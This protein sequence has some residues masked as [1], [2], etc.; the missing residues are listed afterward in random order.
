MLTSSVRALL[1]WAA[2]LVVLLVLAAASAADATPRQTPGWRTKIQPGM[3]VHDPYT[4]ANCTL[5]FLLKDASDAV[6]GVTGAD[7]ARDTGPPEGVGWYEPFYGSRTWAPGMGPV[8]ERRTFV[9]RF[10]R[11]VA[12]VV[13][14]NSRQNYVTRG[15]LALNY[16]IV[17]LDPGIR[18]SGTVAVVGG[19]RRQPYAGSTT[20]A[21]ALTFVCSDWRLVDY[22]D[23]Q[24]GD[25]GV[26]Q[27]IAPLGLG[28]PTF[29]MVSSMYVGGPPC[30]GAPVL[31]PEGTAVAIYGGGGH[32]LDAIIAAAQKQ[33]HVSLRLVAAGEQGVTSS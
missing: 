9:P 4:D 19:P 30:Q 20:T 27:A 14:N 1:R 2:A 31:D 15:G 17:R 13:T 18:Y 6:Y 3:G 16:A 26:T 7:C 25:D 24:A 32:R 5:G 29:E 21:A 8:A 28:S 11:Y 12:Q 10:G 33:L 23:A 22:N